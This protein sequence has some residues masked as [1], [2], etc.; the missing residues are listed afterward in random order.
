ML[1][2]QKRHL[3]IFL[4]L[5]KHREYKH[6]ISGLSSSLK[7]VK[8]KNDPDKKTLHE[9]WSKPVLD[10]GFCVIPSIFIEGQHKLGLNSQQA[11]VLMHL[12]SYWWEKDRKPHPAMKTIA[13]R[14]DISKRQLQRHVKELEDNGL[15]K[16]ISRENEA[17]GKLSNEFDLSGLVERL[18]SIAPDFKEAREKS[19]ELKK[20]A[21]RRKTPKVERIKL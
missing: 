5:L 4:K 19:K 15:I 8:M 12:I 2:C 3:D 7:A 21:G 11:I 20:I 18:K 10:L 9:K 1:I 13:D 14:M 16:R 6:I 17:K